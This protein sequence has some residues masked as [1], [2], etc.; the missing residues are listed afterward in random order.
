MKSKSRV[1]GYKEGSE[2]WDAHYNML[3]DDGV[4]CDDCVNKTRCFG[5]GYSE[6]GRTQC[7][8]YPSRFVLTKK[9]K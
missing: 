5:L 8:F 6:T 4:T 7:D 3:L 9:E 2:D 1:K